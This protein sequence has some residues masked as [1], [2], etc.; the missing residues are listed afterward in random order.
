MGR[1]QPVQHPAHDLT[2]EKLLAAAADTFASAG[3]EQATVRDIAQRAGVNVA[4]INYHFGDKL[5]LYTELIRSTLLKP[6]SP[7]FMLSS[8]TETP[9]VALRRFVVGMFQR[10]YGVGRSAWYAKVM[11]HELVRPT[12][13]LKVVVQHFIKPNAL[14]LSRIVG[15]LIGRPAD[16]R[17]TRLCVHSVIAQTVHHVHARPVIHL[18]WPEIE[19]TPENLE[20][21]ANHVVD[22]S[23][24]AFRKIRCRNKPTSHKHESRISS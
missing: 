3:F 9:E 7:V 20:A 11:A 12:P 5:G 4:S 16:D 19:V 18:L 21:I 2:R 6:E 8:D 15:Q 23:L 13:A 22:F 10:M 1:T 24:A 14:K 17:L